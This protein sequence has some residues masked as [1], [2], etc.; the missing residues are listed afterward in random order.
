MSD[1]VTKQL[2]VSYSW[3][4]SVSRRVYWAVRAT[5]RVFQAFKLLYKYTVL[6]GG[7]YSLFVT[8]WLTY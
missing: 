2:F 8:K 1:Q 5:V 3:R 6:M 7:L 4:H